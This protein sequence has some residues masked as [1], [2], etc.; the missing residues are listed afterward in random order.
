MA[1]RVKGS[2][3][4]NTGSGKVQIASPNGGIAINAPYVD[5]IGALDVSRNLRVFGNE[6]VSG[7][8]EANKNYYNTSSISI[9][10][11]APNVGNPTVSTGT[12]GVF[13]PPEG[14]YDQFDNRVIGA[15]YVPGGVGI[16]KDL[17][18]GGFIYGRVA[19]A[20]T[21]VQAIVQPNNTDAVFYPVFTNRV[22]VYN[23]STTTYVG[24]Y[25]Y[26]DNTGTVH[27]TNTFSGLIYNP[28]RGILTVDKVVIAATTQSVS[29]DTGALIVDGGAGIVG[30]VNIGGD[31]TATNIYASTGSTYAIGDTQ[32]SFLN[33]YLDN[34]YTKLLTNN[35]SG[36]RIAPGAGG[37]DGYPTTEIVGDLRVKNGRKPIG[38]APV[39]TNVLWVTMDGD[40]TNDGAS[41]DP[42]RACR[43]VSGAVKSPLYQPG[44]QIRVRAGH[45]LEDNPI[46]MKPYTSVM[47]SDL[48]T[49]SIEPINK[50]QDLFHVNSGCYLAFMQMTNGRS[51]LLQGSYRPDLNRGAYA[52]AFPTKTGADRID[53]FHSPYIQNC[54]NQNGPWLIDGTMFLPAA[55]VQVPKAVGLGDWEPN[56]SSIILTMT[57]G[58]PEQGMYINYGIQTADFFNARTLLLANKPFLQEQVVEF[59]EQTFNRGTF[60]YNTETCIRD[61]NFIVDAVRYDAALGTNYNS[62]TAGNAYQRGNTSSQAVT[63]TE[64]IQTI[65][66]IEYLKNQSAE[67]MAGNTVA[68][69]RAKAGYAEIEN[70]LSGDSPSALYFTDPQGTDIQSYNVAAKNQL[71]ANKEFIKQEITQWIQSQIDGNY[72]PFNNG[73]TYDSVKCAR[74]VGYIVDALCYDILYGSN[75]SVLACARAY[76]VGATSQIP[77]EETATVAAFN[78]LKSVVANVVLGNLIIASPGVTITQDLGIYVSSGVLS[79]Q[80]QSLISIIT[81][82]ITAG[83]LNSLPSAS[84]PSIS[85]ATAGIQNS[86]N[87]LTSAQTS[88]IASM[89]LYIDNTYAQFK[90]DHTKCARDTGLIVD[91]L[92]IDL[93][94]N[95]TSES[96][97][98]GLQYWSQKNYTGD[99]Q[100][101]LTTTTA[102]I[103]YIKT[104]AASTVTAATNGTF[105]QIVTDRFTDIVNILNTSSLTVNDG[106]FQEWFTNALVSNGDASTVT[107]YVTAFNTLVDAKGTL[108]EQTI[109]YINSGLDPFI[110]DAGKCYRDTGL[111]VDSVVQ[112]LLFA[113]KSQSTFAGLQYWN[114]NN[115]VGAIGSE[116]TTTTNAIAYVKSLAQKVILSDLTGTRYQST[117]TQRTSLQ[118]GT[119]TEQDTIAA[120]FDL[121]LGIL[122]TGTVGITNQIIPNGIVPSTTASIV[123]AFELLQANKY[124]IETEAVAYVEATKNAG[125]EYDKETCAR[126]VG[127]MI[128]SVSFDLLYGGNKQAIQSGVYYYGYNSTSTAVANEIPQTVEAYNYIARLLPDIIQGRQITTTLYQ[129]T[130][131]Q[132]ILDG[133]SQID[134]TDAV[135][136]IE[137]IA[138]I[139]QNGPSVAGPKQP[140]STIMSP[141][142]LTKQAAQVLAA[143]RAFIQAEVL[144]YV[145]TFKAFWYDQTKCRRDLGYM[146]D[147]VAFDLLH[148]GNKQ[149]FKSGA[150]YFG[151]SDESTLS[152]GKEIPATTAAYNYIRELMVSVLKSQPV[153]VTRTVV[154]QDTSLLP[155]TDYE[156]EAISQKID[157][158]TSIIRNGPSAAP[159]QEPI[160]L[161]VNADQMV[162]H[163]YNI[164][165]ANRTFIVAEVIAYLDATLSTFTYN[166]AKCFRDVGILVE[167]VSYDTTFGGNEKSV[168]SGLAYYNGAVSAIAG[169]ETQTVSAIDYLNYLCQK[170]VKNEVCPNL[171]GNRATYQQVINTVLT[172]GETTVRNIN[173][174]FN[175]ITNII[176]NG[177]DA[178]PKIYVSPGP[179][180]AFVSAETLMQANR[181]F[182]QQQTI[183]YINWNLSQKQFPY[184]EVKCARDIGRVLE[185]V[186]LDLLYPTTGTSQTTFAGIQYWNQSDYI[187]PII[188]EEINQTISAVKYLKDTAVKVIQ[189]ITPTVDLV[190][191]Y[192]T[193]TIQVTT[194]E[195]A[196]IDEAAF[197]SKDFD[198]LIG[199]L[200]GDTLGW[201]D[202]IEANGEA[203]NL[204]GVYNAVALLAA[205]KQYL[206]DEINAYIQT[207]LPG[208]VYSTSTCARDV[209]YIIDSISFDLIHGGNK[210][211]VQSGLYYYGVDGNQ[212][213]IPTE[214]PQTIDAFNRLAALASQ[215][216]QNIVVTATYQTV[217]KQ[218]TSITPASAA[219]GA[220]VI[221]LLATL[222]NIINNGPTVAAPLSPIS[223]TA[224]TLTNVYNAYEILK[225]N[226]EFLKA[227][228]IEYID[229][230]Y[231]P[232]SFQYN[233][234]LCYRDTGLIIDAVSQDILVG[235]N[236][237]SIEAGVSYWNEGYNH[238]A[239]QE[240]TTT[241]A[242]NYARDIALKI[243][244]NEPV[245]V[246]TGTTVKQVINPYFQYGGDYMPRQAIRRNF[247]IITNIIENGLPV[248]PPLYQGG[249]IYAATGQLADDVRIPPRVTS[250]VKLD[251]DVYRVGINTSTVGFG[252]DSVIYLGEVP[253][254][255]LNDQQVEQLSYE[256]S[257]STSTWNGRKIDPIGGMGGSLVD[258]ANISDRSPIQSFVYDAFTQVTQGGHGVKITNN[259]YAQLVSVFTIFCSIGVQV[260]NGGIAS[261]VNSNANFGDICLQ[262]KGFG[263]RAFSGTIYNP[264]YVAYPKSPGP[265]GLDQYYPNGFWPNN[266]QVQVF[267]PDTIDRPHISLIMEVEPD[268]GHTNEQ[269]L[270]YFLN[271]AP[272]TGTLTTGSI[273]I[274]VSDTDGINIGDY[275]YIRDINNSTKGGDGVEIVTTGST[276]VTDV[277]Y[278][279]VT[280]NT[281]LTSGGGDPTN[282]NFYNLYFCG[283]AYYTVLSSTVADNPRNTG[284]NILSLANTVTDQVAAHIAA[285]Q[286]LNTLTDLVIANRDVSAELGLYQELVFP[287]I[288]PQ[289]FKPLVTGGGQ[290]APFIDLRFSETNRII[291]EPTTSAEAEA[292]FPSSLRTKT[293]TIPQGAGS[294]ITL[295]EANLD[296]LASEVSAYVQVTNNQTPFDYDRNICRRDSNYII[297]GTIYDVV[298]GTNY[299]T[300]AS[301]LAY[302]RGIPSSQMVT[303]TELVQTLEAI[304]F[305]KD[306]SAI[307]LNIDNTAVD[308]ANTAYDNL[309]EII[310]SGNIPTVTF[311]NPTGGN[312]NELN[313]KDQL[314]TNKTFIQA[315]VTGWIQDQIDSGLGIWRSFTYSEEKCFR[316]VGFIVDALCYD[317]LYGGNSATDICARAYFTFA[318]STIPGESS[319]TV[320]AYN[321][322]STIAQQ[323]IRGQIVT[324]SSGNTYTQSLEGSFASATEA[325]TLDTL[326]QTITDVIEAG[327]LTGLPAVVYPDITWAAAGLQNAVIQLEADQDTIVNDTIDYIDNTFAGGFSYDRNICR[328]DTGYIIDGISYDS[329]LGTNFNAITCGNAYRRGIASS[330]VVIANELPQTLEAYRYL[331]NRSEEIMT[332]STVAKNRAT[333]SYVEL[334]SIIEGNDPSLVTFTD[335]VTT[336]TNVIY[337]KDQLIANKA[338]IQEEIIN[339]IQAQIDGD[340]GDFNGFTYDSAKC[341]RD[342]GYIIDALCYDVLYG[343]N[344]ASLNCAKA[345][346][347]FAVSTIPGESSQ[348]VEAYQRLSIVVQQVVQGVPVTVSP[349]NTISQDTGGAYA[350]TL[351]A[352]L[353][354]GLLNITI[355]AITAG[356]LD[357]L[358]TLVNPDIT[359][360]APTVQVAVAALQANRAT[361][362]E[363]VI[364]FI[365]VNFT[366]SFTYDDDK[367]RRDVK[368]LLRRLIYDLESGGRYNSVMNGLSYWSRNGTHHLVQ[369]G[370]NVRRT[371]LFPD[372]CLVNFYQRSYISASGYVFEYVGAGITYGALPQVGYADPVQGKETVQLSG[373]KVFFTSTD[374]NGDF[375]IGPGLVIS[376]ATGVLSG[377]TFTKSLFANLTPFILAIEG[378]GV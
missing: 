150:Y 305:I 201:T 162:G 202:R 118:V 46:E 268:E 139:I 33:A 51:G 23:T 41:E 283:K 1:I 17:N 269:N 290:A 54:T 304:R 271:A 282:P 79:T 38:T 245:D 154:P 34:V 74:D 316:D 372:S 362:I 91:G 111:I 131:T 353:L 42:S 334:N 58:V 148:G 317:I 302:R 35:D 285:I 126:D 32:T 279:T 107:N 212:S 253:T 281:P 298:L 138:D 161:D 197:I 344:S 92:A 262:A 235:G 5:V 53:L 240:S 195:A 97:F 364:T 194:L 127:Y 186:S 266:A 211:A 10:L 95:S 215:V 11:N 164:I 203:S 117:V 259:G 378:G 89:I 358:P 261:I 214:I 142:P 99:I 39:V 312:A 61:A 348:T 207:T 208:F 28:A 276:F 345:Y 94:Y 335:P 251:Q 252:V 244:G 183:N 98:S 166:K 101:E 369:L 338:F 329:A 270:P 104:I 22:Q 258:G 119:T 232:N 363:N 309:I 231:N 286:Y 249:S 6:T 156:I 141:D 356:N 136:R 96:V 324:R 168:Q 178:A 30:N 25:L 321:H 333:T 157:I 71:I 47:G 187:T 319:Q 100:N 255:P 370:E 376:Q 171:L 56:T 351:E 163:A 236:S 342:V 120:E 219:E 67:I 145:G 84:L 140:I 330:Q 77:G 16:E 177:T 8:L 179:D 21:S 70:I 200:E 365:D 68:V 367:C 355:N 296:F 326:V 121:I 153:P 105:G 233:E 336:N 234:E 167:N 188:K 4:T 146:I 122:N 213:A 172:N 174:N 12:Q 291:G 347:S 55:T 60:T 284:T 102:A 248:V 256:Y 66:A 328:R 374:Q 314:Q 159:D 373:G 360:T 87:A 125:F 332:A 88:L 43:T 357:N 59:V 190:P 308:R 31:T 15:V 181:Q 63:S 273:T 303:S 350:S 26:S 260:D 152:I 103:N 198:V 108:I 264:P 128:D 9:K 274:T 287:T 346:F 65:A 160:N 301:G 278:K 113:G 80:C 352:T 359:W 375:R 323:I 44:T 135:D 196:T 110:Y 257:G 7:S 75:T 137:Y 206:A 180:A 50:T 170:V 81:D 49:T 306:Q 85:W 289:V 3:T 48:R 205:N 247:F 280:L 82:A 45:Y 40:D 318:V 191:R 226:T 288:T 64:Y 377:R 246:I 132:V 228:V 243:V 69:N 36:I 331:K 315:E 129:N 175:I 189:N 371:D 241:L 265:N 238:V 109:S 182:I 217:Y 72:A 199:I 210:Q 185:A 300:V 86:F 349:G 130:V 361:L 218:N 115:Y 193:A 204:T 155:A 184:S 134:V 263:K 52:T 366:R 144:A 297:T 93:L 220:E 18:V 19:E 27:A 275:I 293:G 225:A 320:A 73:F 229:A 340:I 123:N 192:Q 133:G 254:Y 209:G 13:P 173:N 114:Q 176:S 242:L 230:K 325:S 272:N 224:S 250:V 90:F 24:S 221:R 57:Q 165:K 223:L 83:N 112:D 14:I 322:L 216:V 37:S 339:W 239:G 267:L 20:T 313:A 147:S 341:S 124:Y 295:I 368:L 116:I 78:H 76:F 106:S 151:Y 310:D 2:R 311:T 29:T 354:D 294:A 62:V 307:S 299:N 237:K 169:Q 327:S 292:L 222:T 337:A 343:G 277:S 227:E 143:N 158:I 149:S